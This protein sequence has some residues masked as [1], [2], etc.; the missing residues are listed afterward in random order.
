MEINVERLTDAGE[1]YLRHMELDD[2]A[3]LKICL[4]S[5]GALLGLG[6]K[7]KFARRLTGLTCAFLAAGLAVPLVSK[8]LD[9][10]EPGSPIAGVPAEKGEED[11]TE[12]LF[13]FKVEKDGGEEPPARSQDPHRP[14]Q[15]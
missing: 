11:S 3:A 1:S 2:M 14:E 5:T 7:G 13:E 6:V 9:E 8:F 15:T 4:L 10:P 12:T